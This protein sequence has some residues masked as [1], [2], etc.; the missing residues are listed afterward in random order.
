MEILPSV[1]L[2]R[3][4]PSPRNAS[5]ATD[6]GAVQFSWSRKPSLTV[7]ATK[8]TFLFVSS[9]VI[10]GTL[11]PLA[12]E[13]PRT[14]L[15]DPNCLALL[16]PFQPGKEEPGGGARGEASTILCGPMGSDQDSRRAGPRRPWQRVRNTRRS[17]GRL[18][19][20]QGFNSKF[21]VAAL[22]T[23]CHGLAG[24]SA[25]GYFGV[26]LCARGRR[27]SEAAIL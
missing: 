14:R 20:R 15:R 1:P 19:S 13:P 3:I 21:A 17:L 10:S 12:R 6:F 24:H 27:H 2:C 5:V 22:E 18:E 16:I 4:S 7:E 26:P 8:E 25:S 11:R 9:S 23:K